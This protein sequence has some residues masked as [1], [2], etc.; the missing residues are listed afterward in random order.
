MVHV[1]LGATLEQLFDVTLNGV[2]SDGGVK[3]IAA[4]PSLRYVT[5]IAPCQPTDCVAALVSV[6]IAPAPVPDTGTE[7]FVETG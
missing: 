5:L 3:V 2:P 6:A 7:R 4:P 1:P